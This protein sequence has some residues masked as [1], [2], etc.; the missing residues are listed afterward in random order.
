MMLGQDLA[1]HLAGEAAL[2]KPI[3]QEVHEHV[4][5]PILAAAVR[6]HAK[7]EAEL[8]V[9]RSVVE[10]CE[11]PAEQPA[12]LGTGEFHHHHSSKIVKVFGLPSIGKQPF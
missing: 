5:R 11:G 6:R 10:G 1:R 9:V 3:G 12:N 4:E 7:G 8:P 2:D